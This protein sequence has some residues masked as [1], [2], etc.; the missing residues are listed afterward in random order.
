MGIARA[1]RA[2]GAAAIFMCATLC[3][4]AQQRDTEKLPTET[5]SNWVAPVDR[6]KLE[7]II[8]RPGATQNISLELGYLTQIETAT[9]LRNVMI[10]DDKVADAM[11]M[12]DRTLILI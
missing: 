4:Q 2:V 8:V 11:P 7:R 3:A 10:G 1:K 9:S 6:E 5:S 12:T